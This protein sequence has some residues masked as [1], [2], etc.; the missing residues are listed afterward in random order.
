M[1]SGTVEKS[2]SVSCNDLGRSSDIKSPVTHDAATS[3]KQRIGIEP[4]LPLWQSS[5]GVKKSA[6]PTPKKS[7]TTNRWTEN[8]DDIDW[9]IPVVFGTT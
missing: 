4:A 1:D 5:F 3:A 8:Q 7:P 9:S 2:P 6:V